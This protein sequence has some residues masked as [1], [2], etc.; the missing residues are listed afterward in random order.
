MAHTSECKAAFAFAFDAYS[1]CCCIQLDSIQQQQQ[2]QQ[3]TTH[4]VQATQ[5]PCPLPPPS[6][7]VWYTAHHPRHTQRAVT[8]I[9]H[10]NLSSAAS[11]RCPLSLPLPPVSASTSSYA[12]APAPAPAPFPLLLV[13]VMSRL[14]KY[15]TKHWARNQRNVAFAASPAKNLCQ[16]QA[17]IAVA[18]RCHT[19]TRAGAA[20]VTTA[21]W[22]LIN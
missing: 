5:L 9:C 3:Q 13:A 4:A 22:R 2:Q 16:N 20:Q 12:Y 7:F 10:F 1:I 21:C 18:S 17:E 14:Y 6:P 8:S 15:R 11:R 19:W